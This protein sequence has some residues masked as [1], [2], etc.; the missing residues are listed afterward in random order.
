MIF[1][2]FPSLKGLNAFFGGYFTGHLNFP[3]APLFF[4]GA[5]QQ[6]GQGGS[7]EKAACTEVK[8]WK[9]KYVLHEKL[10]YP[11]T[12]PRMR[13]IR[14][15]SKAYAHKEGQAKNAGYSIGGDKG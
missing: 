14:M 13:L 12:W 3:S 1:G 10:E 11:A 8:N 5:P 6:Q 4:Y 15:R 9:S 2:R 7:F